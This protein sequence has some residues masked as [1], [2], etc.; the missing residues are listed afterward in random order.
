M[1]TCS[2]L[3]SLTSSLVLTALGVS[4]SAVAA[5][6]VENEIFSDRFEPPPPPPFFL[7]ENG[8]TVRCPSAGIGDQGDVNGVVYTKRSREQITI[9]NAVTTCTSGITDMGSL[10][11]GA[12]DFN[13]NIGHWDTSSVRFM[14]AMFRGAGTFNQ[15][16]G[17]WDTS[18]VV[19]MDSMFRFAEA[20]N[21]PIGDWDTSSVVNM[22]GMFGD[23][24]NFNKPIGNWDTGSVTS[25][26]AMFSSAIN[27]NQD[28][29]GWC[30][31]AFP[32]EPFMF[33]AGASSWVEPKPI[34][35]TCP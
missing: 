9:A 16:I 21:Q 33:R 10:F 28:L 30:V 15:P 31:E 18:A 22:T 1:R 8:V 24:R 6:S 25:M 34:W 2:L 20:F 3:V 19:S 35:G 29:S 27:F 23:A 7:D 26:T 32:S 4:G 12:S 14:D 13:E 11:A 5:S 17:I